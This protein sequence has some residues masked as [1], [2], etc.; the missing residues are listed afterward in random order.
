MSKNVQ[1]TANAW[2]D[3]I[4]WQGLD[5]RTLKRINALIQECQRTP[6]SGTGKPE[7][8]SG[9]L[10]GYWSRRI[11]EKNRLVYVVDGQTL[12]IIACRFHYD[13]K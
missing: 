10:A 2:N 6:F 3:Y 1:F 13:D 5:K 4:D 12:V 9:N 11:D 8:L 7:Q